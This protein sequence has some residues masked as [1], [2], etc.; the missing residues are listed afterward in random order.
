MP[1]LP[2]RDRHPV[3]V[4]QDITWLSEHIGD[5]GMVLS[6]A[7]LLRHGRKGALVQIE[8]EQVN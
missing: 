3:G 1:A 8:M 6:L 2:Y 4:R 7:S 5:I